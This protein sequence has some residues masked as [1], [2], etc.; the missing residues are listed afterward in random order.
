MNRGIPPESERL[1]EDQ[2]MRDMKA[3][4][5]PGM[6]QTIGI[7]AL[8]L[9]VIISASVG[10]LRAQERSDLSETAKAEGIREKTSRE[11][12]PVDEESAQSPTTLT[13]DERIRIY[14]RSFTEPESLIGPALGEIGRAHV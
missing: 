1:R 9:Q 13:F 12:G 14:R 8:V 2:F 4:K 5:N 7:L 10:E 3:T 11:F 6:K